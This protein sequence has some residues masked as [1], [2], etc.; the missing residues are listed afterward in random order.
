M[1]SSKPALGKCPF[2]G[3]AM[4]DFRKG[5]E[6]IEKDEKLTDTLKRCEKCGF[7]ATFLSVEKVKKKE[8]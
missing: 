3:G 6:R 1:V 8:K 7:V 2:C 5:P 4:A